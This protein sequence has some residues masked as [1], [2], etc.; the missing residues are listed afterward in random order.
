LFLFL[1][2]QCNGLFLHN[3]AVFRVEN[4]NFSAKINSKS[5]TPVPGRSDGESMLKLV[6]QL[7]PRRVVVVRGAAEKIGTLV[8]VSRQVMHKNAADMVLQLRLLNGSSSVES[9]FLFMSPITA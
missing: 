6:Q 9:R 7:K 5:L 1:Q 8:D 2:N 3:S 4:T